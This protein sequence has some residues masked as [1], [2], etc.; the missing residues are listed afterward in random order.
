MKRIFNH[1]KYSHITLDYDF[2][3]LE[4]EHGFVFDE[5]RKAIKLAASNDSYIDGSL[6]LVTGWGD[7]LNSEETPD[8]LRGAEVPIFPQDKCKQNYKIKAK[9]TASMICAG[10]D[11]G[12]KDGEFSL[13]ILRIQL[14]ADESFLCLIISLQW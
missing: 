4:L 8:I 7:T 9:V 11:E 12:G 10:F 3:L 5:T 14:N 1:P 6:C 13:I 2:A